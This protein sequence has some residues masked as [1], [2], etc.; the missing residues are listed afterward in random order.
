LKFLSV[1]TNC[2]GHS[3]F[4]DWLQHPFSLEAKNVTMLENYPGQE[5]DQEKNKNTLDSKSGFT[6]RS[7][8]H[9]EIGELL[10]DLSKKIKASAK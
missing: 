6:N 4:H 9:H 3:F 8:F 2:Q 10:A 7:F 1:T 5:K